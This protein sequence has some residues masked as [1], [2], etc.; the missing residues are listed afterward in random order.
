MEIISVDK[1]GR[2]VL[3]RET[4]DRLDI[5]EK[6]KLLVGV[7]G[8]T[9]ILKKLDV[10][11][12]EATRGGAKRLDLFCFSLKRPRKAFE[13]FLDPLAEILSSAL[14]IS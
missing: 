3:P 13:L 11:K 5:G 4:R 8:D 12:G 1:V 7:K 10:E 6:S 2:I 14:S 9:I